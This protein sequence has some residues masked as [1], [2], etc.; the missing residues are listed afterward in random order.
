VSIWPL[1]IIWT[2]ARGKQ[3]LQLKRAKTE[4]GVLLIETRHG[5]PARSY[6][7]SDLRDL[8][9]FQASLS[10]EFEEGGWTLVGFAP[11]W[12]VTPRHRRSQ[13]QQDNRRAFRSRTA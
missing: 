1:D 3:R 6:F 5:S 11:D 4:W 12:S 7:F 8:M 2:Y 13:A 9:R 10:I